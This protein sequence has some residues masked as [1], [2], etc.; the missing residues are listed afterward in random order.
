MWA[1]SKSCTQSM[2]TARE[3]LKRHF[4]YDSFKT[5]LQKDAVETVLE[6]KHHACS[7]ASLLSFIN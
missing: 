1:W 7:I 3:G 5:D 2:A 4:K 6:R